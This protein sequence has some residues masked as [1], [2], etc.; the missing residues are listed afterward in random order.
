MTVGRCG[1]SSMV[2][3]W[4]TTRGKFARGA[5]THVYRKCWALTKMRAACGSFHVSST[6][7]EYLVMFLCHLNCLYCISMRKYRRQYVESSNFFTDFRCLQWPYGLTLMWRKAWT[8]RTL[9]RSSDES[10]S[11]CRRAGRIQPDSTTL[12]R[13]SGSRGVTQLLPIRSRLHVHVYFCLKYT[14]LLLSSLFIGVTVT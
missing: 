5:S 1:L 2:R 11:C 8:E 7:L 13:P 3:S 14:S 9:R 12:S 6:S 10:W 4:P